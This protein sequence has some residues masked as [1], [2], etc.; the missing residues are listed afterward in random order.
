[1]LGNRDSVATLRPLGY[2]RN[3]PVGDVRL[4]TMRTFGAT[5]FM[6]IENRLSGRSSCPFPAN[7]GHWPSRRERQQMKVD[8]PLDLGAIC[9]NDRQFFPNGTFST[10]ARTGSVRPPTFHHFQR[11]NQSTQ[12]CAHDT[13]KDEDLRLSQGY[14][15]RHGASRVGSSIDVR[16]ASPSPEPSA[17]GSSQ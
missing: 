2:R 5:L 17:K 13:W 14:P 3:V 11:S 9:W 1:M 7:C 16:S 12:L 4:S 15:F 6:P 10:I 8:R